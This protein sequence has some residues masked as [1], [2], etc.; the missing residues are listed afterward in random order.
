MKKLTSLIIGFILIVGISIGYSGLT[1]ASIRFE[2]IAINVE[3]PKQVADWY[4]KYMD[5][6]II[7]ASKKM[8]FVSDPGHHCMFELYKKP[9]VKVSYSSL[10][11]AASHIAFATDDAERLAK[12][13]VEGGA[14]ILKKF[15]NPV[16]DLV[17]NM[18]DPWGN[19]LQVIQRVKPK[20]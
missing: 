3:N 12:K 7:S 17:I 6:K 19:N 20:L 16:G 11:H 4:V 14:K 5:L 8:I 2:H 15:K 1:S 10:S 13:M 18:R 9:G